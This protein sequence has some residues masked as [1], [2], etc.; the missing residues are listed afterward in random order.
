[1]VKIDKHKLLKRG[2]KELF[3]TF[4]AELFYAKNTKEPWVDLPHLHINYKVNRQLNSFTIKN[5]SGRNATLYRNG[6]WDLKVLKEN[7]NSPLYEEIK[8]IYSTM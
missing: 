2:W 7:E 6:K 5:E 3:W 1:M 4:P 8:F